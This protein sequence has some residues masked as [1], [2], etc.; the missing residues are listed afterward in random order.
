[1]THGMHSMNMKRQRAVSRAPDAK[2]CLCTSARCQVLLLSTPIVLKVECRCIS[3]FNT[4][5]PAQI[6]LRLFATDRFKIERKPGAYLSL[7]CNAPTAGVS[8]ILPVPA[9]R[10][11]IKPDNLLLDARGH[12][13]LSDFGLCKPVDVTSLGAIPENDAAPVDACAHLPPSPQLIH[14]RL[15]DAS[16]A[17]ALVLPPGITRSDVALMVQVGTAAATVSVGTVAD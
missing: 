10:R 17:A 8:P 5:K 16:A 11:D 15:P 12:M 1:M 14:M 2:I 4:G 3:P 6:P 7:G 9:A 13:K